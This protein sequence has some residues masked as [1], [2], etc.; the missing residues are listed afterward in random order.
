MVRYPKGLLEKDNHKGNEEEET[1]QEHVGK[2]SES[3]S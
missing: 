1:Y 2:E 3:Y